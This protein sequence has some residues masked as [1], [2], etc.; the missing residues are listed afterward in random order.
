MRIDASTVTRTGRQKH[1]NRT[2]DELLRQEASSEGCIGKM[3]GIE[4]PG[5]WRKRVY[6]NPR[7]RV[8]ADREAKSM[9][10]WQKPDEE[11]FGVVRTARMSI[12][13]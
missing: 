1:R 10:G 2:Q 4:T 12:R 11:L 8:S 6:G 13:G 9:I 7:A 3:G 5:G